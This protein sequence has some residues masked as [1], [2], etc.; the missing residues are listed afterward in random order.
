VN[1]ETQIRQVRARL[2]EPGRD[3]YRDDRI[4]DLEIVDW[5]HK[6]EI[7][8]C[9]DVVERERITQTATVA[10]VSAQELYTIADTNFPSGILDIVRVTYG[11]VECS[12]WPVHELGALDQNTLYDPVKGRLQFFYVLN[13]TANPGEMSIG[14][15][16][17]PDD[18]SDIVITYVPV[19]PRRWKHWSGTADNLAATEVRLIDSGMQ[20]PDDFWI[21]AEVRLT[22]G[23]FEGEERTVVDSV[24]ATT[25]VI[26]GVDFSAIVPLS[27]TFDMGDPTTLPPEWEDLV[28]TWATYTGLLKDKEVENASAVRA[29]YEQYLSIVNQRY[30]FTR[31]E[32]GREPG[33]QKTL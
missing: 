31:V 5:I 25:L 18:T 14:I 17:V 23:L 30:G 11:G 3:D 15:R 29:E 9:R 13:D 2:S 16:P 7:R 22:S 19:P 21:G 6:A 12:R 26:V 8:V 24:E 4:T 28:I 1:L 10:A 33:G 20:H 32:P 27:T